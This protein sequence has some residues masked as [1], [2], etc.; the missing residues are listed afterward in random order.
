MGDPRCGVFFVLLAVQVAAMRV[1]R[2]LAAA[3]STRGAGLV[4]ATGADRTGPSLSQLCSLSFVNV[5][6]TPSQGPYHCARST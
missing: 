3:L 1:S 4:D 2:Q 6:A 5:V